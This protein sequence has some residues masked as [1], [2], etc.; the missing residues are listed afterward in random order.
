[1]SLPT[2]GKKNTPAEGAKSLPTKCKKKSSAVSSPRYNAKI[3][4]ARLLPSGLI[5]A[6][7]LVVHTTHC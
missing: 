1:M 6:Q 4:F 3:V 2:K 5:H 7:C